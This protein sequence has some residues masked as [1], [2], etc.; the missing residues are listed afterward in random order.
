MDDH[1]ILSCINYFEV[2]YGE[3]GNHPLF[4]PYRFNR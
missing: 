1:T 4:D 3:C 2:W